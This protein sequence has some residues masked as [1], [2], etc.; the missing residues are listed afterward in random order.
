MTAYLATRLILDELL[1]YLY[2]CSSACCLCISIDNIL[3]LIHTSLVNIFILLATEIQ[4]NVSFRRSPSYINHRFTGRLKV[5]TACA[6]LCGACLF[7]SLTDFLPFKFCPDLHL[8][9]LSKYTSFAL[10]YNRNI[11]RQC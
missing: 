2:T 5:Y 6:V 11:S 7:Q 1:G 8:E 3:K 4:D 10:S 9:Q